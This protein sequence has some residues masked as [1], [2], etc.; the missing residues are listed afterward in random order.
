M[1]WTLALVIAACGS[2][3]DKPAPAPPPLEVTWAPRVS[4]PSVLATWSDPPPPVIVVDATG[5]GLLNEQVSTWDALSTANPATGAE[6]LTGAAISLLDPH[7]GPRHPLTIKEDDDEDYGVNASIT[8][9]ES[10]I[11]A[12]LSKEERER[13]ELLRV[14][15]GA[16]PD[17]RYEQPIAPMPLHK[18]V[19]E[20]RGTLGKPTAI[21]LAAPT[22][23]ATTLVDVLALTKA[24]LGVV[25]DG[26]VR[27]LRLD[28]AERG[29]RQYIGRA[30]IEA[31]VGTKD[32]ALEVAPATPIRSEPSSL[33][34]ALEQL[35][36]DQK[37]D[38]QTR[39]DVLVEPDVDAQRLIDVLVA[40][41]QANVPMI[42]L[43][44]APTA[45]SDAAKKRGAPRPT[46]WFGQPNAQGDLD[47]AIIRDLVRGQHRALAACHTTALATQP[48]LSGT[49][50]LA[51]FI[52][53]DGAVSIARAPGLD[54]VV[55]ACVE[56]TVKAITFPKPR[57][58]GGVQVNYPMTFRP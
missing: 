30:W 35:R 33:P 37:L 46:L 13:N 57:G 42:G 32:L 23:K 8:I 44:H 52:T 24:A 36:K 26:K 11:R 34:A 2:K 21:I 9:D 19:G 5:N 20:V 14:A 31:R 43:A 29:D 12:P 58:G 4:T 17:K 3:S 39:V 27:P 40:L 15:G 6:P 25:H 7:M 16:A 55:G 45:D 50:Q 54:A 38:R 56:K 1:K 22:S 18:L 47:K 28:F 48:T 49:V 53:P 41:D 10:Q 51:F